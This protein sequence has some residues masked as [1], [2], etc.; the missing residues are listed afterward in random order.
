MAAQANALE[1]LGMD[2]EN[3]QKLHSLSAKEKR[4]VTLR[5]TSEES[6]DFVKEQTVD[7]ESKR[8]FIT[9][10]EEGEITESGKEKKTKTTSRH[11]VVTKVKEYHWKVSVTYSLFAFAGNDP[12]SGKIVL[13]SREA[14]T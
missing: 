2:N 8:E 4:S 1:R 3:F 11:K 13:Q 12:E 6:C 10:I 7:V 5:F 9:E 14:S